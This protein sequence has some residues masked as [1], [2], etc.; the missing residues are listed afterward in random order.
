MTFFAPET[1]KTEGTLDNNRIK[2]APPPEGV[3]SWVQICE[4]II[5]SENRKKIEYADAY[6][7][8]LSRKATQ[9]AE[10]KQGIENYIDSLLAQYSEKG[11]IIRTDTG[12]LSPMPPWA[13]DKTLAEIDPVTALGIFQDTEHENLYRFWRN[14]GMTQTLYAKFEDEHE[15]TATAICTR[16]SKQMLCP[17]WNWR[18]SLIIRKRY[19]DYF[20]MNPELLEDHIPVHA[21]LTLRHTENG[22][23]TGEKWSEE[24]QRHVGDPETFE[25][26]RFFGRRLIELF[27]QFRGD[28]RKTM[29]KYLAGGCYNI[30]VKKSKKNGLHI[31]MHLFMLQHKDVV[32]RS[33]MIVDDLEVETVE[34]WWKERWRHLTGA[35]ETHYERLYVKEKTK[36]G[37]FV[38]RHHDDTWTA[39]DC[40]RAILECLKYNFKYDSLLDEK[41]NFDVP[42]VSEVLNE[43]KRLRFTSRFGS[44]FRVPGLSF[45]NISAAE[46]T[47][48]E[49]RIEKFLGD[50]LKENG[51]YI[52]ELQSRMHTRL[53][54]PEPDEREMWEQLLEEASKSGNWEE[55]PAQGGKEPND[56][57]IE[58]AVCKLEYGYKGK[59]YM[60]FEE[61]FERAVDRMREQKEGVS[62]FDGVNV[63]KRTANLI[64]PLNFATESPDRFYVGFAADIQH[65]PK[66]AL[67]PYA[68]RWSDQNLFGVHGDLQTSKTRLM[69]GAYDVVHEDRW[70]FEKKI[71]EIGVH[72][73][74]HMGSMYVREQEQGQ[75]KIY[76]VGRQIG[77]FDKD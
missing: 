47:A 37:E 43:S 70:R 28:N 35:T 22:F 33:S 24:L 45:S 27:R 26:Q 30:E 73:F 34:S 55:L 41:Q 60:Q 77:V 11:E 53:E 52:E 5:F 4:E 62:I 9:A 39:K 61:L 44:F 20:L 65:S 72:N 59:D 50:R 3:T 36:T 64:N 68:P 76:S 71:N 6:S 14:L 1:D 31:H 56:L 32:T 7:A 8:K 13:I 57:R 25:A 2:F 16:Y 51:L 23:F 19:K 10:L 63:A 21:V 69:Q 40:S 18:R 54:E 75:P 38:K 12:E 15:A 74:E 17:V 49:R 67:R 48:D 42:F 58:Y 66:S 46:L 29:K